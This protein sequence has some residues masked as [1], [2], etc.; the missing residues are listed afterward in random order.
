MPTEGKQRKGRI[1]KKLF[2]CTDDTLMQLKFFSSVLPLLERV[3]SALSVSTTWSPHSYFC[4]R[5]KF[6]LWSSFFS[7]SWRLKT[8]GQSLRWRPQ[9]TLV[10]SWC[11]SPFQPF[12]PWSSLRRQGIVH[13]EEETLECS[14]L[15]EPLFLKQTLQ[16]PSVCRWNSLLKTSFWS[17]WFES[18]SE[19]SAALSKLLKLPS[20]LPGVLNQDE[21]AEVCYDEE[22]SAF[23]GQ[24]AIPPLNEEQWIDEW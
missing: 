4:M 17:R 19:R 22:V 1:I 5:N 16:E 13:L 6:L 12:A 3:S 14:Q 20:L 9:R 15:L 21:E 8:W 2:R 24:T 11:C 23:L 10:V 7:V 18:W